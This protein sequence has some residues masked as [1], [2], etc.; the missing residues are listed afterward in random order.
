MFVTSIALAL[1]ESFFARLAVLPA[2]ALLTYACVSEPPAPTPRDDANAIAAEATASPIAPTP[3]NDANAIATEATAPPIAPTPRNDNDVAVSPTPQ[4]TA[5]SQELP[6]ATPVSSEEKHSESKNKLPPEV[7]RA[8]LTS[9][10]SAP[11]RGFVSLEERILRSAIIARVTMASVSAHAQA[12]YTPVKYLPMI[13]FTFVVHEYLK[14]S[15]NNAITASVL[16]TCAN[17]SCRFP[18]EQKAIDY[19]NTWLSNQSD[20]WWENRESVVF[21]QEDNLI[22]SQTSAQSASG[23]YKFL[24]WNERRNSNHNYATTN[25][26]PYSSKDG[27]SILSDR[28]RVWLPST[29]PSSDASGSAEPRFMLGNKPRDLYPNQGVEGSSNP[30]ISLS[31]LKSRIK[32]LTDTLIS[33]EETED[34]DECLRVKLKLNRIPWTPYS[35][36]LPTK[37]GLSAGTVLDSGATGGLDH[38]DIYFF[39][40]VDKDLFEVVIE[41]NDND[42]YNNYYRTVKTLRPLVARDYSVVYHQMPGVLRPC[43][44]SPVESYT[45]N[46]TA[47]WTIRATAPAGTLH[48]A[49]FDPVAIGA[50]VGA[51]GDNGALTPA[52][53]PVAGGADAE[54]RR[55]D[56]DADGVKIE[57]VNP[58]VSLA[59]HHID[60]IALDGSIAL[61]LDF[62]DAAV[63]D[64]GDVRTFSWGV[65][66]QPWSAG[67]K[68]MLRMSESLA[69]IAGATNDASCVGEIEPTPDATP[70][71]DGQPMQTQE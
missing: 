23:M 67:D 12:R 18:D 52:A 1:R 46:P 4:V 36:E 68:L 22:N 53:F 32:T 31:D 69:G 43:I 7:I 44:G 27:Y 10:S 28:N 35:I 56:W 5:D 51:D 39:S 25:Q 20:R 66:G 49:F 6:T 37:S 9:T 2:L 3:R 65:C 48:E 71:T 34:Y 70:A 8:L 60:F 47:N 40:G 57:I 33:N 11:D 24:P 41:D 59:N 62:G 13:R 29:S 26:Y 21:L 45:N 55:I 15:G 63:A 17:T 38:Y 14:G 42:P 19:A 50:A 54:I 61:R 64:A 58:P 30:D 16:I